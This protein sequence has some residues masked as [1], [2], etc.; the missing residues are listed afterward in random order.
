M[1]T[2]DALPM[3]QA[4]FCGGLFLMIALLFK[5]GE[6]P[7]KFM[8]SLCAFGLA[9]LFGMQWLSILGA[10][11]K[12]GHWP[13]VSIFNTLIFGIL[14]VLAVRARGNVSRIFDLKRR[15]HHAM[16]HKHK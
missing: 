8:P 9:S 10:M 14:F 4:F 1:N 12:A 11:L 5:R 2:H 16:R 15:P 6:S 7:Y 3:L 13:D